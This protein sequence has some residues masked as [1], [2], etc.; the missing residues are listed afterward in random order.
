MSFK[1][2]LL[3]FFF[4]IVR[5]QQFF[6]YVNTCKDS[7]V[8][9]QLRTY[10]ILKVK[11]TW[12]HTKIRSKYSRTEAWRTYMRTYEHIRVYINWN[13]TTI[14]RKRRVILSNSLCSVAV[15]NETPF[16]PF[17]ASVTR[18]S[19]MQWLFTSADR[20]YKAK[21]LQT[22]SSAFALPRPCIHKRKHNVKRKSEFVSPGHPVMSQF[23]EFSSTYIYFNFKYKCTGID[24]E[25]TKQ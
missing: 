20:L 25:R 3:V 8:L 24:I 12:H 11:C 4:L 5:C 17:S 16:R 1:H 14:K 21:E 13:K 22:G 9:A 23:K 2:I 18:S 7:E 15:Q 19:N 6:S 10:S